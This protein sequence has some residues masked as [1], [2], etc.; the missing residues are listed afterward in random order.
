[1]LIARLVDEHTERR[2]QRMGEIADLCAGTFENFAVGGDQQVELAGERRQILGEM[3]FDA[4]ALAPAD[5]RDLFAQIAQGA[6][7]KAHLQRGC[8]RQCNCQNRESHRQC[9][10]ELPD[11]VLDLLGRCSDLHQKDAGIPNI[12]LTLDDTQALPLG[13]CRIAAPRAAKAGRHAEIGQPGQFGGKQR[14]GCP[15]L[16][17][18]RIEPR[19][20]PVPAR[21]GEFELGLAK[22]ARLEARIIARR[23]HVGDERAQIDAKSLI[24]CLFGSAAIEV[25]DDHAGDQQEQDAPGDRGQ[26]QALR[27]GGSLAAMPGPEHQIG[28]FAGGALAGGSI[29]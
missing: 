29:R 9:E 21:H 8:A 18:V 11:L 4:L 22:L 19:D 26:K 12:D 20:L 1:M 16:R 10:F 17:L 2:L 6:Q 27:D 15:D 25:R 23:R 28:G 14:S 7:A 24:E 3:P 13:A 5:G